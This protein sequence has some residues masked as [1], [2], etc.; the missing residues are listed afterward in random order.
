LGLGSREKIIIQIAPD[1]GS[2]VVLKKVRILIVCK[3][4]FKIAGEP[5]DKQGG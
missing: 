1:F 2:P 5:K 4:F 3:S